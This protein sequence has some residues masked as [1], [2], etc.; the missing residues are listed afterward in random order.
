MAEQIGRAETRYHIG[1]LIGLF[2]TGAA[3]GSIIGWLM[4]G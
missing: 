2:L 1:E 4:W 3:V